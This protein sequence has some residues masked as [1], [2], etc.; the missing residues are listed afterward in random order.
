MNSR[1]REAIFNRYD[2]FHP[3]SNMGLGVEG[4]MLSSGELENLEAD[5]IEA[6]LVAM[7]ADGLMDSKMFT[8]A[9]NM[10]KCWASTTKGQIEM[11]RRIAA[12]G[13]RAD[14]ILAQSKFDASDLVFG[15]IAAQSI[16]QNSEI[17]MR[18]DL[19]AIFLFDR[20]PNDLNEAVK[21]LIEQEYV[22]A[23]GSPWG[24]DLSLSAKGLKRY[25]T[26]V[27]KR[28]N[29]KE[30]QSLLDPPTRVADARFAKLSIDAKLVSNLQAR[31]QEAIRCR[32][33]GAA[34]GSVILL[35]SVLE[36][37]LLAVL[38]KDMAKT[39]SSA[40]APRDRLGQTRP[41][42]EW[43]LN[44]LIDVAAELGLITTSATKHAHELRDSRNLIHPQ[45]QIDDGIEVD[46]GLLDIS[47]EVVNAVLN[48]LLSN[49]SP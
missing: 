49:I 43:K 37:L 4:L 5:E 46:R 3:G 11:Q 15:L 31:W 21:M 9:G 36:G 7:E 39:M 45:K 8:A 13:G 18:R 29:L 26:V 14:A 23:W 10:P 1:I 34:L 32:E 20:D 24:T 16:S 12:H 38:R 25:K 19:V 48:S 47:F 33:I 28:L 27:H 2:L 44:S 22:R 42:E 17:K 30:G 6:E 41:I 40:K 35:G